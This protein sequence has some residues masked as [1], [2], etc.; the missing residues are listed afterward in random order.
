[1]GWDGGSTAFVL[2]V[3]CDL[4]VCQPPARQL[5]LGRVHEVA[6]AGAGALADG[7][8]VGIYP[9]GEGGREKGGNARRVAC[10]LLVR[11]GA[12]RACGRRA[13]GAPAKQPNGVEKAGRWRSEG[14]ATAVKRRTWR[15]VRARGQ[16]E[17]KSVHLLQ[18]SSHGQPGMEGTRGCWAKPQQRK[19]CRAYLTC[20]RHHADGRR[21]VLG[22]GPTARAR[23]D[24]L[25]TV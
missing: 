3:D 11:I 15:C 23:V 24:V 5:S 21:Q 2:R 6:A 25:C 8:A 16:R 10:G 4:T 20:D 1:M 13:V 12:A 19:R 22:T 18:S 14:G 9:P 7:V 17:S